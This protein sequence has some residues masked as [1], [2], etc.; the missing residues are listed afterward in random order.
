[1]RTNAPL[2]WTGSDATVVTSADSAFFNTKSLKLPVGTSCVQSGSGV[3]NPQFYNNVS[4]KTRIAFHKKFGK[5]KVEVLDG[6]NA[7]APWSLT[8]SDGNVAL[9]IEYDYNANWIPESYTF[10]LTHGSSTKLKLKFTN[11]DNADAYIDAVIIEPDYT[12]RRPSFYTD[13]PNS[14][15]A[16]T[17]VD[18]NDYV[19]VQSGIYVQPDE[20]ST[21]VEKDLWIDTDDYS[22]YDV[23]VVSTDTLVSLGSQ[24]YISVESTTNPISLTLHTAV[25]NAGVIFRIKN[26]S[27]YTVDI[28][29]AIDGEYMT[30]FP[31]ETIEVISNGAEWS[32]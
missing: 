1:M 23:Q 9:Y 32:I 14:I 4:T 7:D 22:R 26:K 21:P 16:S 12:G 30:L 28:L 5:V 18:L 11:T 13:G 31:S 29:S 6:D 15:S 20:P 10:T 25:G 27:D 17:I 3:V 24:E 2:Y 19:V 8:D